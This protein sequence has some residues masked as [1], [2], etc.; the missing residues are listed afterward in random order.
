MNRRRLPVVLSCGSKRE[1]KFCFLKLLF[2]A[3]WVI[4]VSGLASSPPDLVGLRIA[5]SPWV[6]SLDFVGTKR[7]SW[8]GGL[9]CFNQQFRDVPKVFVKEAMVLGKLRGGR[10]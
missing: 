3:E 5:P 10:T 2:L 1:P 4:W 6:P 7:A 8:N 9:C